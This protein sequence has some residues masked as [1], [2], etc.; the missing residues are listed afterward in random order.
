MRRGSRLKRPRRVR[1][2]DLSPR[3][4]KLHNSVTVAR[5]VAIKRYRSQTAT[6]LPTV[7]G[8]RFSRGFRRFVLANGTTTGVDV[9]NNKSHRETEMLSRWKLFADARRAVLPPHNLVAATGYERQWIIVH[10]QVSR[11]RTPSFA[12]EWSDFFMDNAYQ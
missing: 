4:S 7:P 11:R 2:V 12:T 5:S 8:F 3:D 6:R 10:S 9:F 1:C